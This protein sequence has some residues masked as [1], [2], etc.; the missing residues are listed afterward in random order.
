MGRGDGGERREGL[1]VPY[2][3]EVEGVVADAPVFGVLGGRPREKRGISP[4]DFAILRGCRRL[5][6][7]ALNAHVHDVVAADGARVD[8]DVPAPQRHSVPLFNFEAESRG[9]GWRGGGG[10]WG[11]GCWRHKCAN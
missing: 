5:I 9:D 8:H 7:L 4:C 3:V 1:G 6:C 2:A 11:R 10:G